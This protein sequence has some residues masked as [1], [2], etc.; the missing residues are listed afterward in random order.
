M[1]DMKKAAAAIGVTGLAAALLMTGTFAWKDF[2]QHKTAELATN[3]TYNVT[4]VEDFKEINNW[5]TATPDVNKDVWVMNQGDSPVFVRLNFKEY[6]EIGENTVEYVSDADGNPIRFAVDNKGDFI[7]SKAA[8]PATD[9]NAVGVYFGDT[10]TTKYF[11]VAQGANQ[12]ID[13]TPDDTNKNGQIG[14]YMK[15]PG[16]AT[17]EI[18][19]KYAYGA[20]K[21]ATSEAEEENYAVH[22]FGQTPDPDADLTD[23]AN[24][25]AALHQYIKWTMGDDVME[26]ADW[27][28]AGSKPGNF[29]VLDTDGWA[30]WAAPL[31]GGQKT[32]LLIDKLTLLEQPAGDFYYALHA[33]METVTD[34]DIALWDDKT[35]DADTLIA[36]LQN[37][38]F[39]TGMK[40]DQADVALAVGATQTLT[41]TVLPAD[42][43]NPAL[44]WKTSDAA[45]V[46]V[47][48]NGLI[49][50]VAAGTAT[51]TA[52]AADGSGKAATYAV[53]IA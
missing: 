18:T 11:I 40:P 35:A 49:T 7:E 41:A 38:K 46:T 20:D 8:D 39:V 28:A 17:G 5:D 9:P 29:W 13:K 14:R 45:V 25:D 32:S 36:G 27:V 26:M 44:I 31:A 42:A 30:Y 15:K 43:S 21:R 6:M 52:T 50:G 22:K 23:P 34:D 48:E 2:D 51:I 47:D 16:D 53:T 12:E 19:I 4:L 33:A 10:D 24:W 37:F 3:L 1:A